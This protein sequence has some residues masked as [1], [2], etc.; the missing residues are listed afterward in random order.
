MA[1]VFHLLA[2]AHLDPVWLWDREE[3]LNEGIKT[4]RTMVALLE[5]YPELCFNRGEASIYARIEEADPELFEKIRALI[6][7]GRW[8]VVGGNWIQP[9]QNL[10]ESASMLHQYR[11]G[12][13]YFLERFGFAAAT[14]WAA[15]PFG[16]SAG[17][18]ELLAAAGLRRFSF[19][20]PQ[21]YLVSL[22]GELFYWTGAGG[23][24][25]LASRLDVGWYG[26]NRDEMPR[27][28]DAALASY[29][30][31]R[32]THFAIGFGLGDHGGGASRRQ[33]E[34]AM[35]WARKHP[36]VEVRFSTFDRYF[37]A[38]EAE[39]AAG[40]EVPSWSG[41]LNYCLRG[42]YASNARFKRQFR[43]AE[44]SARLADRVEGMV[45]RE[46]GGKPAG[47]RAEWESIAFNSFHDILPG[48][49]LERSMHLAIDELGGAV[50]RA[51]RRTYAALN[52]LAAAVDVKV[53]RPGT[54]EPEMVA[55]V[56]FNPSPVPYRGAV[57]VEAS[58][59]Y[60]PIETIP[61]ETD[62]LELFDDNDKPLFFQEIA[63][64]HHSMPQV[65]WRRRVLFRT[66]LPPFGWK[67]VKLGAHARP[68]RAAAPSGVPAT[69]ISDCAIG[70]GK[71]EIFAEPGSSR[72]L[73]H[74]P[75]LPPVPLSL[76][77]YEDPYGSWGDMT[78]RDTFGPDEVLEVWRIRRSRVIESGPERAAL[79]VELAGGSS[80][81]A[82]TFRLVREESCF[83]ASG[84]L[85]W[86]DRSA[87]LKL[88][89]PA[90]DAV[91]YDVPGGEARRTVTG[92]VPGIRY[93]K[94][95]GGA[96]R[97]GFAS[98]A[99]YSYENGFGFFAQTLARGNRFATDIVSGPEFAPERASEQGELR[100]DFAWSG[101][102]EAAPALAERLEFPI[103][104][105]MSWPHDGPLSGQGALSGSLPAG[106]ELVDV[107]PGTPLFCTFQNRT[108]S[109]L[110][111][112]FLGRAV[113]LPP[114]KL[115]RQEF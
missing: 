107:E 68:R 78:E 46:R 31:P 17:T 22:P 97:C 60:R 59:D 108:A 32:R 53:P 74:R 64:E 101:D 87:R 65:L 27:R 52:R 105:V 76:A 112:Q 28:L 26:S 24:R 113:A 104:S 57:E 7:E 29:T 55:T 80:R 10:A 51:E 66:E 99:G 2:N 61:M 12:Q 94:V 77:L 96:F 44:Q 67:L 18:P 114:W 19:N 103:L 100:F 109:P 9:D 3:G 89:F 50:D 14:G 42:C 70:N 35:A 106:V 111:F 90:G 48:T 4:C 43:R 62:C 69:A 11:L 72:I 82:L 40:L 54:D 88:R 79:W 39:I 81:I 23:S 37:E 33:I 5:E 13:N 58:L 6:R 86:A 102:P 93:A 83:T 92:Q 47:N 71:L 45:L 56:L 91:V 36:E 98:N 115:L 16:H 38:V 1:K 15:D 75:E 34:E 25:V 20:R 30:D 8:G 49:C 41:E 110:E 84:R 85:L 63:V 95:E 21:P 73:I